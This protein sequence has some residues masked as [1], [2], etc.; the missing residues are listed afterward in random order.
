MLPGPEF[1]SLD[2]GMYHHPRSCLA[3][4][5]RLAFLPVW[6]QHAPSRTPC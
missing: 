3:S 6:H 1:P 5:S 2:V 4:Q